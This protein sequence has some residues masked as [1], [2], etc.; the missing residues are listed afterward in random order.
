[1]KFALPLALLALTALALA[2]SLG[3][4]PWSAESEAELATAALEGHDEPRS[5]S[6][7]NTAEPTT[8]IE[9]EVPRPEASV[10]PPSFFGVR[11]R[12]V[13][14]EGRPLAGVPVALRS[15]AASSAREREAEALRQE[16]RTSRELMQGSSRPRRRV[17]VGSA[18]VASALT[19]A[20]AGEAWFHL[21][22]DSPLDLIAACATLRAEP[23]RAVAPA[24]PAPLVELR[25]PPSPVLELEVRGADAWL[26]DLQQAYAEPVGEHAPTHLHVIAE[27]FELSSST[28]LL[29]PYAPGDEPRCTAWIEGPLVP[30]L[31]L[32]PKPTP[33][34]G[35]IVLDAARLLCRARLRVL[36]LEEEPWRDTSLELRMLGEPWCTDARVRS[37]AEGYVRF[38]LRAGAIAH[39]PR[40]LRVT[41]PIDRGPDAHPVERYRAAH[42]DEA[43][44]HLELSRSFAAGEEHDLGSLRQGEGPL[45]YAGRVVDRAGRPIAGARVRCDHEEL[46]CDEE[47]RFQRWGIPVAREV[48]VEA[49]APHFG[50]REPLRVHLPA[51]DLELLLEPNG[52]LRFAL[53]LPAGLEARSLMVTAERREGEGSAALWKTQ[54]NTRVHGADPTFALEDLAPARYRFSIQKG[55][56]VLHRFELDVASGEHDLGTIDLRELVQPLRFQL[57]PALGLRE[58]LTLQLFCGA[59]AEATFPVWPEAL[60][61]LD[62]WIPK[63]CDRWVLLAEGQKHEG[64]CD[65]PMP[66]D[67]R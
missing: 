7:P 30:E 2:L 34:G 10:T 65:Q 42:P 24:E 27:P 11:V 39:G 12:V 55:R 13:D 25:L 9:R 4:T 28:K 62:L 60:G 48:T 14:A 22:P 33:R 3:L 64:R 29:V 18:V 35:Q 26:L 44:A 63:R 59:E 41:C 57:V 45:L 51:R 58:R 46:P 54:R 53:G 1:M 61:V 37:D 5:T 40:G 52:V 20:E 19:T 49:F 32:E 21:P 38:F 56:S 31:E 67:L 66:I 16:L 6:A 23:T 43:E 15:S 47:G 17:F 36:R 50:Q 8:L